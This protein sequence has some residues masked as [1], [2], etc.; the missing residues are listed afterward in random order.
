MTAVS[1]LSPDRWRILSPYLDDALAMSDERRA[2]W[3]AA[4]SAS[5]AALAGEL[6]LLAEHESRPC[7]ST[8]FRMRLVRT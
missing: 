1:S 7:K 5:D 6:R 4:I 2:A 8:R 3:L